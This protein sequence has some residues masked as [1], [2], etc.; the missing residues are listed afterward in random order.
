MKNVSEIN[1]GVPGQVVAIMA[2]VM[3]MMELVVVVMVVMVAIVVI[4]V[5]MKVVEHSLLIVK[6]HPQQFIAH[7]AR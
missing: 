1:L 3:V 6:R 5:M 2:M 4:V 7:L